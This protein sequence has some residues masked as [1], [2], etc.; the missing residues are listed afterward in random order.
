[1]LPK[2]DPTYLG[3]FEPHV[4]Q[5]LHQKEEEFEVDGEEEKVHGHALPAGKDVLSA[6]GVVTVV[7]VV[8]VFLVVC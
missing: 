1:M 7:G 8:K 5:P 2:G 6:A 4:A 3:R